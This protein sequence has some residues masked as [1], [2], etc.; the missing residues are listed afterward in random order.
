MEIAEARKLCELE[1]ENAELK[2]LLAEAKFDQAALK[3]RVE[4]KW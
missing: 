3:E 2:R 4:G 1:Q